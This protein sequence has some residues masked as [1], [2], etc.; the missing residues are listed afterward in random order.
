MGD[1][2]ETQDRV[3][4]LEDAVWGPWRNNG[5]VGDVKAIRSMLEEQDR[6]A[7]LREVDERKERKLDRRWWVGTVLA[8]IMAVLAAAAIVAGAVG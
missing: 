3:Q 7:L 2:E 6:K 1:L 8:V 4:R 5:L